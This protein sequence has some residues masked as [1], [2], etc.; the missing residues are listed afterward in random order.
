MAGHAEFLARDFLD[1][2]GILEVGLF[3]LER[4]ILRL[5]R[6][7]AGIRRFLVGGDLLEVH[8]LRNSR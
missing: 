2:R 8:L 6:C 1:V 7:E 4:C 3:L 5:C